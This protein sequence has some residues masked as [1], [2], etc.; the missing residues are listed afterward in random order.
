[1]N[2][3]GSEVTRCWKVKAAVQA[4]GPWVPFKVTSNLFRKNPSH[5]QDN[6]S[7]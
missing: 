5:T 7:A 3:L 1:M 2:I 4:S 6:S